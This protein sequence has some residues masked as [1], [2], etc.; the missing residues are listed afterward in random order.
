MN[1]SQGQ[2][3]AYL[4][5]HLMDIASL[6][7]TASVVSLLHFKRPLHEV[8]QSYTALVAVC[9]VLVVLI[10]LNHDPDAFLP[11]PSIAAMLGRVTL[12][13]TR[14][15]LCGTVL[16]TVLAQAGALS[17]QWLFLWFFASIPFMA[18]HRIVAL[19]SL[20]FFRRKYGFGIKKVVLVGYGNV[21]QYIHR[22]TQ[23]QD[24]HGYEIKAIYGAGDTVDVSTD[25]SILIIEDMQDILVY[26]I[27]R[28]ID[29]VWITLPISDLEKLGILQF[30]LAKATYIRFFPG[31][32][33]FDPRSSSISYFL[34]MQAVDLNCPRCY[35]YEILAKEV[36]DRL[37]ALFALIMLA[38]LFLIV[39]LCIKYSSSG[40]VF[41]QQERNGLLGKKFLIYKFRSMQ[42]QP[43]IDSNTVV[44]ARRRDP[45]VTAVGCFIRRTS[46]DELP[47][48][49][50]V[51]KGDMSVVGPRPHAIQH[52]KLYESLIEGY[53]LRHCMKPGITGWAQIHG[54]RGET[55]T[56]EKMT[57]RVQFDLFYIQNWSFWLD[58][59]IVAWTAF[60]GWTGSNAY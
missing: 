8:V 16:I 25:G 48:F 56:L 14:I 27:A 38:P 22:Q 36:F 2:G 58:M 39:A 50:N 59:R 33:T 35:N 29:E 7:A 52:N 23:H 45:R 4:V 41:F 49:I 5:Q 53:M 47:Q 6:V 17:Y 44:Q 32:K 21:G 54:L 40:P 26:V 3:V 24:C 19:S 46:I 55:D 51:L 30:L 60:K 18:A 42:L 57:R 28:Q 37:F 12:R 31:I 34:G 15:L 11:R 1:G 9:S 20:Q 43:T 10:P 13:W